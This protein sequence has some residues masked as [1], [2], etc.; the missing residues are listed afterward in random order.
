[1]K[2]KDIQPIVKDFISDYK[3]NR[4]GKPEVYLFKI[5]ETLLF[6]REPLSNKD[7]EDI[8]VIDPY[9]KQA[10]I[11]S[12]IV[13]KD[14]II[15][16]FRVPF[17]SI[18]SQSF[19][20][21]LKE[22]FLDLGIK[23]ERIYCNDLGEIYVDSLKLNGLDFKKIEVNGEAISYGIFFLF[24]NRDPSLDKRIQSMQVKS[25]YGYISEIKG[26]NHFD[27]DDFFLEMKK[28]FLNELLRKRL[29]NC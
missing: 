15:G 4:L 9:S 13:P 14:N 29:E 26:L 28:Y 8:D 10:I 22:R 1:M 11:K 18:T 17:G 5:D 6:R 3:N 7:L 25:T 20:N 27:F 19:A 2:I 21:F 24:I 12:K 23:E 16:F